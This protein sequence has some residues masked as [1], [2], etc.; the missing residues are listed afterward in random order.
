MHPDSTI[1]R[2]H[3][4]A[5]C[6]VD[7]C[8]SGRFKNAQALPSVERH[9]A[10]C[11]SIGQHTC[12]NTT[13]CVKTPSSSRSILLSIV[14]PR[15]SAASWSDPSS[16]V[17][18]VSEFFEPVLTIFSVEAILTVLQCICFFVGLC[19]SHCNLTCGCSLC[20]TF[21]RTLGVCYNQRG[22]RCVRHLS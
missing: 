22:S 7:E 4:P 18:A 19:K 17:L 13:D 3:L 1:Q 9:L 12:S 8:H 10:I 21:I 11:V 14:L 20:G 2:L 5:V 16:A 15:G 6:P